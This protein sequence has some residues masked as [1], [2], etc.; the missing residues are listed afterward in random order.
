MKFKVFVCASVAALVLIGG[1][2]SASAATE[3]GDSCVA[4]D[5]A[6][7]VLTLFEV[8][9]PGNPLP[10]AAPSSGVLTAWKI[11]LV[12][13]APPI[14]QTLDVL[15]LDTGTKT[16]RVVGESSTTVN[17]G[18]NVIA[19]RIP[20]QA[21]D[22]LAIFGPEP[23]GTLVCET[24]ES[25]VYGGYVGSSGVGGTSPYEEVP[26]N[27][28]I[29]AVGVIEPDA[30]GD[31]F[32]DETQDQCPQS[33]AVQVA[34]PTVK[35][36]A[37]AGVKKGLASIVVTTDSQATVTVKGRVK[38]GKGKSAKLSGGT[39][40]VAVGKLAKFTLL[41]PQ[42]LRTALE[43]LPSKQFL[44]LKVTA[45]APNLSSAPSKK[46]LKL[47]LRGLAKPTSRS[48]KKRA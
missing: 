14:P 25:A 22:R 6:N 2:S 4:N 34:C 7:N 27:V 45:S 40:I 10:T 35:L 11:S 17:P 44:T 31:G 13:A 48:H 1:V 16:A 29:P 30:D 46:I 28:R 39:Q 20:V 23:I 47:H 41:F 24:P 9:A 19:T 18:S 32:G 37:S 15:H 38:L 12:G 8:S 42:K 26:G 36:S 3:F 43:A 21:G 5:S 33:A